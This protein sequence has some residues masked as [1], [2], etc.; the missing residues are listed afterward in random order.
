MEPDPLSQ[1]VAAVRHFNRFYT[2]QIGLITGHYLG[3]PFSVTEARV[4][5]E[6]AH[7]TNPTATA[8]I[9]ELGLDAGYLSRILK[10][11][12]QKGLVEKHKSPNDGRQSHLSLTAKGQMEFD[13]LNT[14]SQAGIEGLLNSVSSAEQTHIVNAMQTIESRLGNSLENKISSSFIIREPR[15]GDMGWV[16]KRH[17]ELYAEE[18]GWDEQF[19]GL[20]A[21]IVAK[22]IH[23]FDK[24]RERCWIAERDGEN[25][26]CIFLV[27]KDEKTA[28]L[29]L[30][31][32]DP[33]ARGLGL[34]AKLIDECIS[35]ARACGYEKMILW[36]NSNL[37]AA[38]HLYQKFGFRLVDMEPHH[39]Y[40]HD[41]VGENWELD[42]R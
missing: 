12:I 11:F 20:V 6:L 31:L 29:R 38:R 34:G 33:R 25:I 28:K 22:F 16:V 39:S 7:L 27:K 13:N 30:L 42:L 19:E 41:L 40:G 10:S 5:Y 26:G 24:A 9:N 1:K 14:R 15:A 37:F 4:L 23:E 2:R 18:Y 3:S 32:V 21:E 36:T 17:G 35:Y 8:L